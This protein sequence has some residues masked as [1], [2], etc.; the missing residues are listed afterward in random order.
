MV[1]DIYAKKNIA[2][3]KLSYM[4]RLVSLVPELHCVLKNNACNM[5]IRS[6]NAESDTPQVLKAKKYV[7]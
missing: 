7:G 5:I 6:K 1:S 3:L 4:I 2:F